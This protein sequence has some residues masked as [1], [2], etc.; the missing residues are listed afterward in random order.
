[1]QGHMAGVSQ[2]GQTAY[3]FGGVESAQDAGMIH[4][5]AH[6]ASRV[7]RNDLAGS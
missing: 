7:R 4:E 1:M 5:R 3:G 2:S 6:V